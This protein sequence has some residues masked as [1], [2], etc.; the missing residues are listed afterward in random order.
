MKVSFGKISFVLVSI[1]MVIACSKKAESDEWP[2]MDSFHM[3]MAEAYHPYKDSANV[4]PAKKLAKEMA[5]EAVR[6]Q[7]GSLPEKV[8]NDEVKALLIKIKD[9]TRVFAEGVSADMTD[10]EIGVKLTEL[11]DE[12]HA[13]MEAW[14][15]EKH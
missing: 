15:G 3:I 8:N 2:E 4:E 6:W 13:V 10:E 1:A 9:D 11:H 5:D 12:F 14:H 7:T